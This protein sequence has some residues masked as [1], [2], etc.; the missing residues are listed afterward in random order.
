MKM[1][2]Y[3]AILA[4]AIM[5]MSFVSCG[6]KDERSEAEKSRTETEAS[7][8]ISAISST[9][10]FELSSSEESAEDSKTSA[11][12]SETDPSSAD[13]SSE[14]DKNEW[15]VEFLSAD[16]CKNIRNENGVKLWDDNSHDD[17]VYLIIY[18]N[19]YNNTDKEM[20]IFSGDFIF[21]ADGEE[22]DDESLIN[23]PRGYDDFM[24][25]YVEPGDCCAGQFTYEIPSDWK[26]AVLKYE[27]TGET[28]IELESKNFTV[29]ENIPGK[30]NDIIDTVQDALK[31]AD[32]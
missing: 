28:V 6:E 4:A 18:R 3:T 19:L 5:S 29:Q 8:V 32:F 2:K 22:I 17:M 11:T 30:D 7:A 14:A 15:H 1:K 27:D 16:V 26:N 20:N 12:G 25:I 13:E 24:H 9:E 23:L 31:D 10:S 21:T